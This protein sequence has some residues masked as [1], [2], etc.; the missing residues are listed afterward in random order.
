MYGATLPGERVFVIGESLVQLFFFEAV[1][2][3]QLFQVVKLEHSFLA[4]RFLD[5]VI[6]IRV[7]A[8]G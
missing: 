3:F 4:C 1:S 5:A 2:V 7:T 8:D 6:K